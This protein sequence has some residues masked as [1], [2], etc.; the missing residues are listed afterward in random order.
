L[1]A[2][3]IAFLRTHRG[4][5]KRSAITDIAAVERTESY[6]PRKVTCKGL[7][8][9][10]KHYQTEGDDL[11]GTHKHYILHKIVP[12]SREITHLK[13]EGTKAQVRF[14]TTFSEL[15]RV[16]SVGEIITAKKLKIS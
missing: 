2:Q 4:K 10:T 15:M 3:Y 5:G 9:L 7:P 13:G 6:V 12:L 14:S 16:N 1:K 8:V 11:N